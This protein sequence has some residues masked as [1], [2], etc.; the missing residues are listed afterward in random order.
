MN[1]NYENEIKKLKEEE[2]DK[3]KKAGTKL[4][5]EEMDMVNGGYFFETLYDAKALYSKGKL[6]E[7][8]DISDF[9]WHWIS[10]SEKVDN[11]WGSM[12]I[13]VITK[14]TGDNVYSYKGRQITRDE[15]LAM[16]G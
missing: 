3:L 6:G 16:L 11:A 14:P 2:M 5:D 10:S 15:A 4:S 1:N 7:K 8:L 9:V 12:G 13:H